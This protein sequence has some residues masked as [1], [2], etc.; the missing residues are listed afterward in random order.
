MKMV[1]MLI[2]LLVAIVTIFNVNLEDRMIMLGEV[3]SYGTVILAAHDAAV[4]D[5]SLKAE[6]YIVFDEIAGTANF[7]RSLK[8]N[9]VLDDQLYPINNAIF[10][11][12][13]KTVGLFFVGDNK[14]PHDGLGRPIY[15]YEFVQ[16]VMYRNEVITLRETLLGPSVVALIEAPL[17]VE[18]DIVKLKKAVYRYLDKRL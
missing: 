14:V 12:Q 1:L 5:K 11:G 13:I 8:D 4:V 3:R 10:S 9:L 17:N 7:R 2:S 15:P 16:S 6:G 18:G